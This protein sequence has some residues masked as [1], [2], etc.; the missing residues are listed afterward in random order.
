[1]SVQHLDCAQSLDETL[2]GW[3]YFLADID[4]IVVKIGY[5]ERLVPRLRA[6]QTGNCGQLTFLGAMKG[7]VEAA[8]HR[9]WA[10]HRHRGEWFAITPDLAAYIKEHAAGQDSDWWRALRRAEERRARR[11]ANAGP[12]DMARM[13][14]TVW[15]GR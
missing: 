11:I 13:L 14:D 15:D 3:T 12:P 5:A 6:L 4:Q 7:N 9:T 2:R 10:A 1:M 8:L